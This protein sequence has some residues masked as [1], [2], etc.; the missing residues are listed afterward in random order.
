MLPP[1][2]FK[3][4]V[5]NMP[6]LAIDLIVRSPEGLVLLGLRRNPPARDFWFVPGGRVFK[7]ESSDQALRRISK[8]ELGIELQ[9]R[10]VKFRGIYDHIYEDNVFE[11]PDFNTH[12]VVLAGECTLTPQALLPSEEQHS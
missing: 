12:Y 9:T 3:M 7:N 4:A 1:A 5:R 11:D 10:D 2:E 6:L 8:E